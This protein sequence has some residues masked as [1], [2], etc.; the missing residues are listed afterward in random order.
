MPSIKL[1]SDV[2]GAGAL[3]AHWVHTSLRQ[4]R[5]VSHCEAWVHGPPAG[6]GLVV[7]VNVG[8][9]V[10]VAV[11]V[12]VGV[13]LRQTGRHGTPHST[14]DAPRGQVKTKALQAELKAQRSSHAA[15]DG[16]EGQGDDRSQR[17]AGPMQVQQP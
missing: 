4:N 9:A 3:P 1:I 10:S 5:Q 13:G 11:G 17:P 7:G 6:T 14:K 12:S 15:S 16:T 2:V 8:V